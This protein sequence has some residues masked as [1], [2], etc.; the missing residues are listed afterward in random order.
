MTSSTEAPR[1]ARALRCFLVE[2]SAVI[3]QNLIATLEEMLPVHI[4][5]TAEDEAGAVRWMT[6]SGAQCD[7]MIIDIFLKGGTGLEVLRRAKVLRPEARLAV[8][9]NYA[10]ADVRRRCLQLGADRVF[11]K[12]AELEELL[13]FCEELAQPRLT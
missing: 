10:T 11:D 9:S 1:N 4:V 8:L 7:L 6:S 5:G 12:S 3:R 2:D 13:A